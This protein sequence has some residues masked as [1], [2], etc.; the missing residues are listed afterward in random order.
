MAGI[1]FPLLA[2]RDNSNRGPTDCAW[3]QSIY[4]GWMLEL[5][6]GKIGLESWF[7]CWLA[8]KAWVT[9]LI[10]LGLCLLSVNEGLKEMRA[11]RHDPFLRH[12]SILLSPD[13]RLFATSEASSR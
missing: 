10:T 7:S 12:K 1:R 6:M 3:G 8:E 13:M 5:R 2:L 9:L 4:L 11:K